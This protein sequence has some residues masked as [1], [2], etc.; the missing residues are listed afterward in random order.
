MLSTWSE[1]RSPTFWGDDVPICQLV[2]S[3]LTEPKKLRR[4]KLVTL[5]LQ[6]GHALDQTDMASAH[7][8]GKAKV[9]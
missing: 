3:Y 4:M 5:P 6:L 7:L 1:G 2:G 8:E 9:K